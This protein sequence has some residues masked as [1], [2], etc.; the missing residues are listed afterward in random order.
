MKKFVLGT[1]ALVMSIVNCQLS[2]INAAPRSMEQAAALAA[3]F[4]NVQPELSMMRKAPRTAAVMKLAHTVT[5]P[6]SEE[7]AL[8]VFNQ[9]D[10]AGWVL[11]SADDRTL[12]ILGYSEK[13]QFDPEKKDPYLQFWLN[14]FA[15]EIANVDEEN[16]YPVSAIRRAQQVTAIGPLLKDKNGVEITWYQETPYNNLLPKDNYDNTRC[17][18]GCVATAASQIMFSWRH[19][20]HGEGSKEYTWKNDYTSQTYTFNVDYENTYYDWDNM[21][22]SYEGKSYTS[23]QATAV[24]TLMRDAGVACNM[25]Y[26]GD[27]VGGSGAWTDDM[28]YGMKKYFRYNLTK[29]ITTYSKNKYESMKSSAAADI[30]CEWSVTVAK[31]N[32]YFNADLEA[33]RPILMGGDSQQ[34]GGHEFVC[35]GR[36]SGGKFHINWGWEGQYNDAYFSL[37][38]LNPGGDNFSTNIDALIGLEPVNDVDPFD[39]TWKADG[40]DFATTSC[41]GKVVLPTTDPS[42]CDETRE[43]VGWCTDAAYA[44]ETTAPAFVKANDAVEEGTVFYAVFA[45]KGEGGASETTKYTFTSKSWEDATGSWTSNADGLQKSTANN[46]IQVTEGT[47]GA[48]ATT[49]EALSNITAVKV[50]YC[51]NSS[52]GAGSITVSAGTAKET[53]DVTK[54]GGTTL[55]DVDFDLKG[56]NGKL[57]F[58]VTCTT[59][60]IYI[61]SITVTAGAGASYSDYSTVCKDQPTAIETINQISIGRKLIEN[62]QLV[63]MVDGIRYNAIGQKIQ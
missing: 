61:N 27:A 6:S 13:G 4:T 59:N 32:E 37:S 30:D 17:L 36:N 53:K 50:T 55:R 10:N 44:S 51:T 25:S 21:L 18:T 26:G 39:V 45:T 60:S 11:V 12:D 5:K 62:G 42:A 24:A 49:K 2:T 57:S 28:G 29:F 31:F 38:A 56:A 54:S 14:H 16:A 15:I 47:S 35:D 48:G 22:P 46:G 20:E 43:F 33:G 58:E 63:I 3:E 40:I 52:K 34:S 23:A 41:K 9:P 7:A 8:Y 1:L 19:P